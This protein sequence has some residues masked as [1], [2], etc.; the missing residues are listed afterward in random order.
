MGWQFTHL[1]KWYAAHRVRHDKF[2]HIALFVFI[3]T[4]IFT[5]DRCPFYIML[6]FVLPFAVLLG[7]LFR[8]IRIRKMRLS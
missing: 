2:G 4:A 5:L 7:W 1:I 6:A 8:H 3:A